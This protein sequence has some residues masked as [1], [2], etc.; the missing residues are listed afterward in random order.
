MRL[1]AG[2]TLYRPP[3]SDPGDRSPR[4]GAS[5]D[6]CD[7]LAL[8]SIIA[9]WHR[10]LPAPSPAAGVS[11]VWDSPASP[12]GSATRSCSP[13]P[14][15]ECADTARRAV[16]SAR[17]F[18]RSPAP[19]RSSTPSAKPQS[20]GIVLECSVWDLLESIPASGLTRKPGPFFQPVQ[21]HLQLADL[22][23]EL[24]LQRLFARIGPRP[25]IGKHRSHSIDRL[26]LPVCDL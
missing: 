25:A 7:A 12:A 19:A 11:H 5:T 18:P 14:K 8:E 20:G 24:R 1:A 2:Y 4:R 3:N 17:D 15:T 21:F 22:L 13:H 10:S 23:V 6:R 16:A 26:F 9:A